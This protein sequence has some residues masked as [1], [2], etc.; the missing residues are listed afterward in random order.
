MMTLDS[1]LMGSSPLL[2]LFLTAV[3]SKG[4]LALAALALFDLSVITPLFGDHTTGF[5][6]SKEPLEVEFS[7]KQIPNNYGYFASSLFI[8]KGISRFLFSIP[9]SKAR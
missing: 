7:A 9:G 5:M 1:L 6:L 8:S 4:L 2:S 3:Q